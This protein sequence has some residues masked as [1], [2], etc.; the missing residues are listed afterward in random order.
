MKNPLLPVAFVAL[1]ALVSSLAGSA[2]RGVGGQDPDGSAGHVRWEYKVVGLT[3]VHGRALEYLGRALE[4]GDEDAG[5]YEGLLGL[6]KRA[7]D[8][9]AQKNEDL[10]NELGG[11]GWELVDYHVRHMIFKRPA[12]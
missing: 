10:L 7:D 4:G 1:V 12:H 11:E 9:L 8:K 5:L 6:A 3:E 2:P